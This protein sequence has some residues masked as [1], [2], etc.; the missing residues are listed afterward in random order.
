MRN[1]LI[2]F[3]K[4]LK[5]SRFKKNVFGL[6]ILKVIN[7]LISFISLPLYLSYLDKT[8]YGVWLTLSSMISWAGFFDFGL[9]NGL[10]NSL[11][12]SLAVNN[13]VLARK[14][15]STNFIL[16]ITIITPIYLI[17]IFSFNHFNWT[18]I[19]NA[20]IEFSNNINI[21]VFYIFTF[22]C[23]RFLSA[24]IFTILLVDHKSA[25]NETLFTVINILNLLFLFFLKYTTKNSLLYLG[26]GNNLIMTIIPLLT[27]FIYFTGKYKNIRPSIYFIDKKL[28][29]SLLNQGI[30]FFIIQIS[31]LIL[32]T[33]DNMIISQLFSPS[34]VIPYN[35]AYKLFNIPILVFGILITPLWSISTEAY[36]KNNIEWIISTTKKLLFFFTLASVAVIIILIFSNSI[37]KIWLFDKVSVDLI[38]SIFMAIF[39]IIQMFNTIFVTL[40]FSIGTIR[41][42]TILALFVA[43]LNIPLSYLFSKYFG[44]GPSGVI[45]A[46]IVCSSLNLF[47]APYQFKKLLF[48][49]ATGIW[50]K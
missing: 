9:S 4:I 44:L 1:I 13:F 42:Q 14:Y 30:G 5:D 2:N 24:I 29:R 47:F 3:I 33:T 7:T 32:F 27:M 35:V 28:V 16:L 39:S 23:I 11:G 46:T 41:L 38:I 6:F 15:V 50:A 19:L 40:I 31:S 8:S 26:I 45:L 10:R 37:Y 17:F 18:S 34:D 22:F 12:K 36:N 49:K 21:L 48:K 25:L 43:I 20:P